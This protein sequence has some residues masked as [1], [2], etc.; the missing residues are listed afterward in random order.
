MYTNPN[1][2]TQ[3]PPTVLASHEYS[4]VYSHPQ[5]PLTD[6]TDS[7]A[8]ILPVCRHP[9]QPHTGSTDSNGLPQCSHLHCRGYRGWC[10]CLC[11]WEYSMIDCHCRC[12][13]GLLVLMGVLMQ[14]EVCIIGHYCQGCLSVL[15]LQKLQ[16]K[17]YFLYI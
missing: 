5:Q 4:Y 14:V 6:S 16:K 7:K 13:L 1:N 2:P 3:T 8:Y 17:N 9:Q 12:C 10:W 15:Y 11:R